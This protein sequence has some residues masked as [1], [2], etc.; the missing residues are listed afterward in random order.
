MSWTFVHGDENVEAFVMLPCVYFWLS[1]KEIIVAWL[2][3][4]RQQEAYSV[5][6]LNNFS[7]PILGCKIVHQLWSRKISYPHRDVFDLAL[8]STTILTPQCTLDMI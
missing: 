3:K 8:K 6:H 1:R 4:S 2:C 7:I 5:A